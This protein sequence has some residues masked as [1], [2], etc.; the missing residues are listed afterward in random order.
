MQER[1]NVFY[2]DDGELRMLRN[3]GKYLN[4]YSRSQARGT[5][6]VYLIRKDNIYK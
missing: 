4:S 3:L 2:P 1:R 6:S 5:L